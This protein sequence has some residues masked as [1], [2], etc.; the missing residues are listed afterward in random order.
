MRWAKAFFSSA[1]LLHPASAKA[2]AAAAAQIAAVRV[3]VTKCPMP[4]VVMPDDP[5]LPASTV[6]F[7]AATKQ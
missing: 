7:V 5:I 1:V 2:M 3:K 4:V 6:K